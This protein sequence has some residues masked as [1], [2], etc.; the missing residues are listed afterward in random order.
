[1]T[2]IGAPGRAPATAARPAGETT[3][4]RAVSVPV[5]SSSA[6]SSPSQRYVAPGAGAGRR[7]RD[8]TYAATDSTAGEPSAGWCGERT[9]AHEPRVSDRTAGRL[10]AGTAVSKV[11]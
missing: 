11:R 5:S 3:R 2:T 1:M 6:T 10:A 4:E 8:G 9:L 7:S